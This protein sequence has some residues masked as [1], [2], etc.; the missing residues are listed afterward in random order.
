[1]HII[2]FF[3]FLRN[4]YNMLL[5]SQFEPFL[6]RPPNTLCME[7]CQFSY[8][9]FGCT[10]LYWL[11]GCHGI[12]EFLRRWKLLI[13]MITLA[14]QGSQYIYI[15]IYIVLTLA[16]DW[17]IKNKEKIRGWFFECLTRIL[18]NLWWHMAFICWVGGSLRSANMV[19]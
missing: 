16:S 3:F 14:E 17:C 12:C 8:N 19:H 2:V 7:I 6:L 10:L 4:N 1:M 18:F 13:W 11:N 15:Y 9:N 5:I